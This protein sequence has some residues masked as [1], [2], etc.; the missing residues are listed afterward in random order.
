M[1]RLG[2]T[3]SFIRLWQGWRD[4]GQGPIPIFIALNE[5]NSYPEA[6][7]KHFI[8]RYIHRN[9]LHNAVFSEAII[10]K[11]W[12]LLVER[13]N[14]NPEFIFLYYGS[15]EKTVDMTLLIEE[16]E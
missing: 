4:H 7:R 5:Y 15:N 9:Y 14:D 10:E 6:D 12:T 16:F 11:L 1:L 2:K 13:P 8:F 3:V